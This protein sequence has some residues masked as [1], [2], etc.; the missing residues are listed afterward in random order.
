MKEGFFVLSNYEAG[1][2]KLLNVAAADVEDG[3]IL[4]QEFNLLR[5]I[6]NLTKEKGY[7]FAS[8]D[9]F[10]M[11]YNVTDRTIRRRLDKLI[12]LGYVNREL[13][14]DFKTCK[15]TRRLT[16]N[17]AE[18]VLAKRGIYLETPQEAPKA[19]PALEDALKGIKGADLTENEVKALIS[20]EKKYDLSLI[21]E[22]INRSAHAKSHIAW[23][24]TVLAD[25][26]SKGIKLV[27]D[28]S[29][30]QHHQKHQAKRHPVKRVIRKELLPNEGY[31]KRDENGLL[32]G[33]YSNES[34]STQSLEDNRSDEEKVARMKQLQAQLLG[35]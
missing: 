26:A 33:V 15:R 25:W 7:C 1:I 18:S 34:L 5:D 16:I 2:A 11:E 31:F 28:L 10:M 23:I 22:C 3:V 30:T 32:K 13:K 21:I 29:K 9:Y 6:A 19:N 35:V 17:K 8:N 20:I 24:M 27:A 14:F 4:K 12:E